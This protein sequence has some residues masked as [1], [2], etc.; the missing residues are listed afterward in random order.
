MSGSVRLPRRSGFGT[1]AGTSVVDADR[2]ML[3]IGLETGSYHCV[4]V[5]RRLK[6]VG[7]GWRADDVGVD[8]V[9][10]AAVVP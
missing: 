2:L 6:S 8:E 3:G 7:N 5:L 1:L 4:A 10:A 9:S